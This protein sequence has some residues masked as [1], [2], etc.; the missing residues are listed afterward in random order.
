MDEHFFFS[1]S[2]GDSIAWLI[3]HLKEALELQIPN[4]M[5]RNEDHRVVFDNKNWTPFSSELN[6]GSNC[7]W[8]MR[9]YGNIF[10][11]VSKEKKNSKD[12]SY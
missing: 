5:Q 10:Q 12:I 11:V 4:T 2:I 1:S 8:I 3:D 7:D 9:N 6:S